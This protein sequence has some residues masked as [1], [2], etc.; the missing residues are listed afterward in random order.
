MRA[1][2]KMYLSILFAVV[3]VYFLTITLS[4]HSL[5]GVTL[6]FVAYHGIQLE[7]KVNHILKQK[8]WD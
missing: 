5:L 3:M 7:Y 1:E 6:G 4:T 2:T 8:G